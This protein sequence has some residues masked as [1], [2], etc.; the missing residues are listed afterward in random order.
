M[1][2]SNNYLKNI[3]K[4]D[5]IEYIFEDEKLLAIILRTAFQKEGIDFF[6]TF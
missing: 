6:Y 4:R 1:S 5:F 2:Y 3:E